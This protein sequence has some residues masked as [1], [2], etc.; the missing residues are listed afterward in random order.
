MS[1][2]LSMSLW[3]QVFQ[4][5]ETVVFVHGHKK[6]EDQKLD[7][8]F[9][10]AILSIEWLALDLKNTKKPHAPYLAHIQTLIVYLSLSLG[11]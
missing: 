1:C 9:W 11:P 3:P 6:T 8:K 4:E 2:S 7:F 10:G 5:N